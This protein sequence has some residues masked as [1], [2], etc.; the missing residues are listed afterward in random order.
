MGWRWRGQFH[1]AVLR[2][3]GFRRNGEFRLRR[4]RRKRMSAE[5]AR[6]RNDFPWPFCPDASVCYCRRCSHEAQPP[7]G[8]ART[9]RF[10]CV[11]SFVRR[12]LS[13][14]D[15]SRFVPRRRRTLADGERYSRKNVPALTDSLSR[16][17]LPRTPLRVPVSRTRT[18]QSR[19]RVPTFR[20][21]GFPARIAL[22]H[23][24]T[25][26]L[27]RCHADCPLSARALE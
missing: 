15:A 17:R 6:V 22:S 5:Q 24:R 23:T 19:E 11:R 4:S 14:F 8:E 21:R 13:R 12:C 3:R 1:S 26:R 18:G 9:R 7:P 20:R 10:L 25:R 2:K 16:R 27:S